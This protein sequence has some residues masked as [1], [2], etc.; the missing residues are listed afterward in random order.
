MDARYP[1][2]SRDSAIFRL[3]PEILQDIFRILAENSV[4]TRIVRLTCRYWRDL[5]AADRSLPRKI[6]LRDGVSCKRFQYPSESQ[7]GYC[8]HNAVGLSMALALINDAH[9]HFHVQ[10]FQPR[11]LVDHWE[12]VPWYLFRKQCS[13]LFIFSTPLGGD[14][15]IAN[16]LRNIPPLENLKYFYSWK[17]NMTFPSLLTQVLQPTPVSSRILPTLRLTWAPDRVP[18]FDPESF[19]YIFQNLTRFKL[20][21]S[22]P[23]LS[24]RFLVKLF[25]SFIKLKELT[26]DASGYSDMDTIRTQVDW[27]FKLQTLRVKSKY[28]SAFPPSV[29]SELIVLS[30]DLDNAFDIPGAES[31]PGTEYNPIQLSR[32]EQFALS[33]SWPGLVQ[34]DAPNLRHLSLKGSFGKPEYLAQTRLNPRS[35]EIWDDG[36]RVLGTFFAQQSFTS[37]VEL[38]IKADARWADTGDQLVHLLSLYAGK[39]PSLFPQ[40]KI[41]G[42]HLHGAPTN[43][44]E[45]R[46]IAKTKRRLF[47]I[48]SNC[49]FQVTI[50]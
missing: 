17:N 10:I 18:T 9:F 13:G 25:S 50:R 40:L 7:S 21:Y 33:G 12:C 38:S 28:I 48:L 1:L 29:L 39:L 34:V 35:I 19:K 15:E 47:F 24:I 4:S 6:V 11:I 41:I 44:E 8:V 45:E 31:G 42:V 3:P 49:P 5:V 2:Q 36:C 20:S 30:E 14:L 23:V 27:K 26:W 43:V 46:L 16:V 32:L 37:L 22:D